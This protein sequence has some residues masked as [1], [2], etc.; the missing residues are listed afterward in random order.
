MST[1]TDE[2]SASHKRALAADLGE[3]IRK[4]NPYTNKQNRETGQSTGEME[5]LLDNTSQSTGSPT[6]VGVEMEGPPL[7]RKNGPSKARHKGSAWLREL[8]TDILS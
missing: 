1:N 5:L 6:I 3:L 2:K 7:T 8:N 4:L